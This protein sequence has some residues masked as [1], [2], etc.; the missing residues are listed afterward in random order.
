M[1]D[2]FIYLLQVEKTTCKEIAD[3]FNYSIRTAYRK[4]ARLSL[5]IPIIT[6][7]GYS[8]G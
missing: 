2:L 1:I 5:T 7:Q 8:G 4:V 3:R 6:L